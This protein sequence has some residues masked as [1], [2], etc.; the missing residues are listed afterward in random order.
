VTR[1][2][3]DRLVIRAFEE[4]DAAGWLTLVNDPE[5]DRFLPPSEPLTVD[6]FAAMLQARHA[7]ERDIGYCM[8]AVDDRKT[9]SLIG[10]CGI[11]PVNEGQGPEIDLAYHFVPASWNNGYASEAATAVLGHAFGTIGID[12]V[13]AVVVPENVGSWRVMEK[14]GMH[15]VGLVDYYGLKE[16][17]KYEAARDSWQ[18]H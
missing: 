8:W 9:N 7:M 18:T 6:D 5:V 15:Y 14:A 1:L 2:E 10:Q 17:K 3:T 13:M 16:L 4:S 11:R 12:R